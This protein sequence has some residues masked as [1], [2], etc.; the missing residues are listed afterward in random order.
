[1]KNEN[2]NFDNGAVRCPN[3]ENMT[4]EIIGDG[5]IQKMHLV[6]RNCGTWWMMDPQND[7]GFK[8]MG[9]LKNEYK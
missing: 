7:K 5:E 4:A 9:E 8:Y 3:C 1:M 2:W 6:C